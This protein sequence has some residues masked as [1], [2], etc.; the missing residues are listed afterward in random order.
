MELATDVHPQKNLFCIM[1]KNFQNIWKGPTIALSHGA[2]ETEKGQ[3]CHF[4]SLGAMIDPYIE[5]TR[6]IFIKNTSIYIKQ[7]NIITVV[8]QCP[9]L[10]LCVFPTYWKF[11][12]TP[13]LKRE[14]R[15]DSKRNFSR[16]A[17]H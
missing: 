5:V 12:L 17:N 10:R 6:S 9:H 8:E 14:E 7:I 16:K 4:L 2:R 11:D 1:N 3:L 15:V 13:N